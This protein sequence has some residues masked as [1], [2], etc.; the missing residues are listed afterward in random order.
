MASTLIT[1]GSIKEKSSYG[2][3]SRP[4]S[5]VGKP[6]YPS[7]GREPL[8]V[9]V[10]TKFRH[11]KEG[12]LETQILT[13]LTGNKRS[14]A[15]LDIIDNDNNKHHFEIPYYTSVKKGKGPKFVCYGAVKNGKTYFS[16]EIV[17]KL[18]YSAYGKEK[19]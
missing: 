16:L 17:T 4:D 12:T 18:L 5:S 10:I 6:R 15:E 2:G 8:T 11:N 1:G 19:R 7:M 9:N 14:I 13:A 3:N